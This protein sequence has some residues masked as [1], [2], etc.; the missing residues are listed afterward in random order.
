M[1]LVLKVMHIQKQFLASAHRH[2]DFL[3]KASIITQYLC[4]KVLL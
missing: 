1:T 2:K 4:F 3:L